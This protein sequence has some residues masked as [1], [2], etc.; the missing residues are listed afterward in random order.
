MSEAAL[1]MPAWWH[2]Q[3]D[4]PKC[5]R[6]VS[7]MQASSWVPRPDHHVRVPMQI[8]QIRSCCLVASEG[9]RGAERTSAEGIKPCINTAGAPQLDR[10]THRHGR[11]A[12]TGPGH[13]PTRS[14]PTA[15]A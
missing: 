2:T 3:F 14:V 12:P 11:S 4:A 1:V 15:T 6:R 10:A 8:V 5:S 13:A 9:G 7:H